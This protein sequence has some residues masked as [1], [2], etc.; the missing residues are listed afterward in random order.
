MNCYR[1]TTGKNVEIVEAVS[2]DK[3]GE[4]YVFKDE[5]REDVFR[6]AVKGTTI[7]KLT[8]DDEPLEFVIG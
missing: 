6:C 8:E 5:Q 4:E 3:D 7:K 2:Y 1:V